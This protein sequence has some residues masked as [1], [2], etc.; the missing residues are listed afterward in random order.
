VTLS[1]P[2]SVYQFVRAG[3]LL[4]FH[5]SV[6]PSR[7]PIAAGTTVAEVTGTL[8]QQTS[9]MW[10]VIS[11]SAIAGPSSWWKLFSG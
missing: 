6:L 7:V 5:V 11:T 9:I 3:A 1:Q 8:N 10:N 4:R 2:A